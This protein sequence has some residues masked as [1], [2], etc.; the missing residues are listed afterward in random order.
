MKFFVNG[1][2]MR[3]VVQSLFKAVQIQIQIQIKKNLE[4]VVRNPFGP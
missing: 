2:K 1:D 4:F 3:Q